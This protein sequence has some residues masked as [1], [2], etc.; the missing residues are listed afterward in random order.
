LS[1][2]F[3]NIFSLI[4]VPIPATRFFGLKR[5]LLRIA[6]AEVG[7]NVRCSSSVKFQLSGPLRIGTDT[8]I[9]HEVLVVGGDAPVQIGANCDIAPRVTITT[10]THEIDLS[11]PRVA[12]RGYS[13]PIT[14]G[15]GCWICTG[16]TIL[17]GSSIG[18]YC[19]VTAGAVV[20]GNFPARSV[21]GG[22]PARV[23]K[24]V[25]D[26]SSPAS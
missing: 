2:L 1:S 18:P 16:A 3:L 11:G 21:I 26:M 17:G 7:N 10:G 23:I 8:W 5:W 25:D 6:G 24:P 19:I 13:L 15:N 14:I 22:V 4:C 9:G 20:K 12:G